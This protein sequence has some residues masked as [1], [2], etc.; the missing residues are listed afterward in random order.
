M[1]LESFLEETTI[2]DL[3][4]NSFDLKIYKL[5]Q[6]NKVKTLDQI[7]YDKVD[8]ERILIKCDAREKGRFFALVDVLKN[9]YLN[10]PLKCNIN[11]NE[12]PIELGPETSFS[13]KHAP[14]YVYI[15]AEQHISE[16]GLTVEDLHK[17]SGFL[18]G[19]LK[20]MRFLDFLKIYSFYTPISFDKF[21]I[22]SYI[23]YYERIKNK[24]ANISKQDDKTKQNREYDKKSNILFELKRLKSQMEPLISELEQ[25]NNKNK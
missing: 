23:G 21:I 25:Q 16:I 15:D 20:N 11:F 5:L 12:K 22:D 24:G 9:K 13:M 4:L 2:E 10:T 19:A 7:V 1:L 18:R 8:L 6:K 14:V 17:M 3:G